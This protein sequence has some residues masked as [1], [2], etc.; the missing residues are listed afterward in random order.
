M[1]N[2]QI[3]FFLLHEFITFIY[4][5]LFKLNHSL[6]NFS[7]FLIRQYL[8]NI[9]SHL[10]LKQIFYFTWLNTTF[11][12]IFFVSVNQLLKYH[13]KSNSRQLFYNTLKKW[14]KRCYMIFHHHVKYYLH[15]TIELV[16]RTLM[17]TLSMKA[18]QENDNQISI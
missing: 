2:I 12:M 10:F 13:I 6:L 15:W 5:I 9:F 14:R 17:N 7:L 18:D 3:S 16:L 8:M 1:L 11:F 4:T